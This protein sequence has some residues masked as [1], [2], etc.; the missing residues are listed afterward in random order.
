MASVR[1]PQ[2]RQSAFS[3]TAAVPRGILREG[4]CTLSAKDELQKLSEQGLMGLRAIILAELR[5]QHEEAQ[6]TISE[7]DKFLAARKR[8][9]MPVLTPRGSLRCLPVTRRN[10]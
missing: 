8:E 3:R 7:L 2:Q 5:T 6:Q 1:A 10:S 4:I 9:Q